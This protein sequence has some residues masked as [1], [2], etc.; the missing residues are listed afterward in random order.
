L[1]F[2]FG[3]KDEEFISSTDSNLLMVTVY[4]RGF[5]SFLTKHFGKEGEK[6]RKRREN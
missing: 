2:R 6:V 4:Q 1:S 3:Q 5:L